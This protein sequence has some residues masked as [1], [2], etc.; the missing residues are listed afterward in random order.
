MSDHSETLCIIE[1][2]LT[3]L[4]LTGHFE[5]LSDH[6]KTLWIIGLFATIFTYLNSCK[7]SLHSSLMCLKQLLKKFNGTNDF[8]NPE[9]LCI[10]FSNIYLEY[11]CCLINFKLFYQLDKL[12][13]LFESLENFSLMIRSAYNIFLFGRND[14]FII[15]DDSGSI[16]RVFAFVDLFDFFDSSV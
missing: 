12:F 6:F 4:F 11:H 15:F 13:L 2:T 16:L 14:I 9:H 5:S 7:F 8:F 3:I 1:L 10:S